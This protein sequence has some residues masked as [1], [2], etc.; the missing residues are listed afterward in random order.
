MK[1]ANTYTEKRFFEWYEDSVS[2]TLR[3]SGA[4]Y[5]GGSEV[6]IV[7]TLIF[8]GAQITSQTNR[9]TVAWVGDLRNTHQGHWTDDSG[10]P[11]KG[12]R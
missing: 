5:G 8:D 9:S 12:N 2:V 4:S 3:S 11:R 10:D 6:L 7:E 1:N